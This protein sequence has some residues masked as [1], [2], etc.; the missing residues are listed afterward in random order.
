MKMQITRRDTG[1]TIYEAEAAT[2]LELLNLAVKDSVNLYRASLNG[3]SLNRASLN[4][5]SLNGANL[6]RA[7]LDGASLN[8]ANLD[9][10]SLDGASLNGATIIETG[11]T[12][13]QYLSEIVPALLIAGGRALADVLT[14]EHWDCHSWENC[15]MA[16]A[17]STKSVSGVP[18]LLKP[19]ADQFIRYFD[20]KLIPLEAVGKK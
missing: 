6:N 2:I 15:P 14:R 7:N 8:R 20:S 5:A 1:V 4:G 17:F 16:A 3:A 13:K 19:R 10:A 12:W 9:G 18:L 11:E